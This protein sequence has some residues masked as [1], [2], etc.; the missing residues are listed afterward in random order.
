MNQEEHINK[1]RELLERAHQEPTGGG[2]E[3]LAAEMMWGAFCHCPH[4]RGTEQRSSPRQS[5]GIPV[6]RPTVGRYRRREHMETPV[7]RGRTTP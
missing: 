2:D 7:R 1:A 5:R 3:L 6:R 4:H